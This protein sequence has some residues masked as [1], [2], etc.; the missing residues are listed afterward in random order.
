[1]VHRYVQWR[2][3]LLIVVLGTLPFA[4]P[5]RAEPPQSAFGFNGTVSGFPTREFFVSGGGAYGLASDFVHSA[6][7]FSCFQDVLQGP[8]SVSINP[9]DPG[10]CLADEGVRWDTAELLASTTL[11]CTGS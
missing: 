5:L 7:G 3:T 11:K 10:P 9:D 4:S 1:M 6:G 8:L 2:L